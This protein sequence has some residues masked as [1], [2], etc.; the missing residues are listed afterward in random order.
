MTS[1]AE[2]V[3]TIRNDLLMSGGRDARNRLASSM[4]ESTDTITLEFTHHLT[5]N[6]RLSIGYEDMG[7][8][9]ASGKSISVLRGDNG[10]T[11]ATHAIG[12]L[13]LINAH[14]TPGQ[15]L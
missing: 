13:V 9:G 1:T 6:D 14:F 2:L 12:D 10:T 5:A 11:A 4:T 15:V 8:W 3:N 7:V